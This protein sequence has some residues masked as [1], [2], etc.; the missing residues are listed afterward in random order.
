MLNRRA[1]SGFM[2]AMIAVMAVMTVL[3]VFL[4]VFPTAFEESDDDEVPI[5]FLDG[6]SVAEGKMTFGVNMERF[7]E[8]ENIKGMKVI[9][10]P[11][12][13]DDTFTEMF[14]SSDADRVTVRSGVFVLTVDDRTLNAEYEAAVWS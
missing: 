11:I 2:G 8:K 4:A 1:E 6:V 7:L 12:G 3:M 9:V 10:R 13:F 5:Y 14:G